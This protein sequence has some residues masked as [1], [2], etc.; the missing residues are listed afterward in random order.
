MKILGKHK[1]VYEKNGKLY[2]VR[3]EGFQ[4]D[5]FRLMFIVSDTHKDLRNVPMKFP[6]GT[7]TLDLDALWSSFE[8][9][10]LANVP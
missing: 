9:K 6:K 1:Q 3:V 8:K 5:R 10:I 2:F 4:D 7:K